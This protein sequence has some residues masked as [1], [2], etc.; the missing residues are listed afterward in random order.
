MTGAAAPLRVFIADDH[1]VVL[2]GVRALL[3]GDTEL[4][5]VGEARDGVTALRMALELKPEIMVLDLS[6]PGLNGV[7]VTRQLLARTPGLQGCRADSA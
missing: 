2:A 1:P 7:D 4:E 6:M 3:N 5:I